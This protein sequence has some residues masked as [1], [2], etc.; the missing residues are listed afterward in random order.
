MTEA[1]FKKDLLKFAGINANDG[2]MYLQGNIRMLGN[3]SYLNELSVSNLTVTGNA[4]LE[5][6]RRLYT[7][8]QGAWMRLRVSWCGARLLADCIAWL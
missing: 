3:G 1:A 2:T 5:E 4:V 8:C 7:S 6:M